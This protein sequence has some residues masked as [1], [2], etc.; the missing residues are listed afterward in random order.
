MKIVIIV[1]L[2]IGAL[3]NLIRMFQ[4]LIER[5]NNNVPY[6]LKPM[7]KKNI[8]PYT[9]VAIFAIAVLITTLVSNCN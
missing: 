8:V 9:I 1:L 6:I 4:V 2:G 3:Y 5:D 7:E